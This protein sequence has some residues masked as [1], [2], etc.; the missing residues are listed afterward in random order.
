[1]AQRIFVLDT[2]LRDGEQT[3]GVSLTPEKK[4]DI[5]RAL[6]ELG[7]DVIEAGSAITSEG[8]RKGIK[9][10]ANEGLDAEVLSFARLLKQDIDLALDCDVDGIFLVAPTSDLHIKYKLSSTREKVLKSVEELVGYCRQHGLTV[11]LCCED[12]SRTSPEFLERVLKVAEKAKADRFTLADTVG[13]LTPGR[14]SDL[15]KPLAKKA[16]IPLGVHCH[17]DLGMATANTVAAVRSGARTVDV[18]VNG[19]GERAG[20]ASLEEVVMALKT[21]YGY[22]LNVKTERLF[23]LSDLVERITG[24]PV[25]PNKAIVGE[26]AFTHEAG[27]HVDGILKKPGTY[28]LLKP[29]SVGARRRFVLGKHVG[30]KSVKKMLE[31]LDFKVNESQL[32]EVFNQ[33]KYIGDKGKRV[34]N[35][36]LEAIANQVLGI[37]QERHI[38]LEELVTTAGNK[39]TPT[40]SV[41]MRINGSEVVESSTGTGPVDAA[42]NAIRKATRDVPFELLEYHVDAISG[43]SDAVVKIMVKLKSKDKIITSQGTGTDIVLASVDAM[44]NGLNSIMARMKK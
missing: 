10:I 26:N 12:G 41:K 14:M 42:I 4:L 16:K 25:P 1:M 38:K 32:T 9:L 19:L 21:V 8:E 39:F 15:M 33:V 28:E 2:T 31:E 43:G 7:V 34:T 17:D 23:K 18:T 27:I 29:E 6:D 22:Q 13:A 5:A 40:A 11:D 3:P 44:V 20:N 36:D 24:I 37:E 35:V 30:M